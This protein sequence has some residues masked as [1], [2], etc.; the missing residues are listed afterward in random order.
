MVI[1]ALVIRDICSLQCILHQSYSHQ[2][3][4]NIIFLDTAVL[5]FRADL[6]HVR[7]FVRVPSSLAPPLILSARIRMNRDALR[8]SIL[9]YKLTWHLFKVIVGLGPGTYHR[10]ST[11]MWVK[12][13]FA[14][15]IYS[16]RVSTSMYLV[17]RQNR[18]CCRNP[19]IEHIWY[20]KSSILPRE[21]AAARSRWI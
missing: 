7:Q 5:L 8:I 3:L 16:I 13:C 18:K 20:W 4:S 6:C 2:V 15:S 21:Q 1:G 11:I 12:F 19:R 14:S 17:R 10:I 9:K